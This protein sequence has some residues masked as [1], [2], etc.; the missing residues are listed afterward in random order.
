MHA[1]DEF[2]KADSSV[3]GPGLW[4]FVAVRPWLRA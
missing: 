2:Y 4:L 3:Q 1:P